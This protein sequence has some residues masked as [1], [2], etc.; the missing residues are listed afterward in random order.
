MIFSR[1]GAGWSWTRLDEN[2]FSPASIDALPSGSIA[3][4]QTP[5]LAIVPISVPKKR[6]TFRRRVARPKTIVNEDSSDRQGAPLGKRNSIVPIDL[7]LARAAD[8][9]CNVQRQATHIDIGDLE[10]VHCS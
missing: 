1:P 2:R 10:A 3:D 9:T 5:G 7:A 4:P 6:W 8:K